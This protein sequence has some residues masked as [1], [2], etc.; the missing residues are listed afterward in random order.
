V[1]KGE[2]KARFCADAG[3]AE[4]LVPALALNLL[5]LGIP[6]LYYGTEQGFDGAGS[7]DGADRYIRE[8]M[9]GGNFGA[10][11]SRGVHFFNE[12]NPVY[13]YIAEIADLRSRLIA[14]RRGRQYL[15][16]ISG[17][18]MHFGIPTMMGGEIR[19]VVPWS[20]ILSDSE[21][22]C[23]IN[24][25]PSESRGAWVTIDATLHRP[26]DRLECEFSTDAGRIG[27]EV[28]AEARNGLSVFLTLPAASFAVYS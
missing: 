13:K 8:S 2:R 15:R 26:G 22:L 11:R 9:F 12:S 20:R 10:F 16:P 23:A 19:S 21:V 3:V 7:G 6:C 1:S 27:T 17:D 18:G 14:L 4:L 24:T 5:T 25:H 28:V